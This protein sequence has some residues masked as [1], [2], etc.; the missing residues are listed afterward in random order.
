KDPAALAAMG[1]A[2]GDV[3]DAVQKL[4]NGDIRGAM[5]S[6]GKAWG[7]LSNKQKADLINALADH[8]KLPPGVKHALQV[9]AEVLGTPGGAD[10]L[11]RALDS[12]KKGDVGGTANALAEAGKLIAHDKPDLAV[13]FLNS[14]SHLPGSLGKLFADPKLN[15]AI[16]RSGAF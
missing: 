6:L 2:T 14:L 11:G 10:A 4:G 12:V 9:G 15:E 7:D 16:V 3:M 1:K 5:Q 13:S 8:L